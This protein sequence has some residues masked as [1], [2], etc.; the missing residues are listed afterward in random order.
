MNRAI[1]GA[2]VSNARYPLS[3]WGRGREAMTYGRVHDAD[4]R[5]NHSCAAV[6]HLAELVRGYFLPPC[7]TKAPSSGPSGHLLPKGRRAAAARFG[8]PLPWQSAFAKT[9][10]RW[11][12]GAESR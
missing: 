1:G 7:A 3:P 11:T 12:A 10:P 4:H 5:C 8:A 6:S 2:N 9:A